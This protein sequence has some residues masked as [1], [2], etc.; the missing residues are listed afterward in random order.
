MTG[1]SLLAA[2]TP[3]N[4]PSRASKPDFREIASG[5]IDAARITITPSAENH[6]PSRE[7]DE[8]ESRIIHSL[9]NEGELEGEVNAMGTL[10]RRYAPEITKG[11][12]TRAHRA[13]FNLEE[14]KFIEVEFRMGKDINK[15][16]D[17]VLTDRGRQYQVPPDLA[18]KFTNKN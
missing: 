4:N 8:L 18:E 2:T 15:I 17:I 12:K 9:Q 5:A 10:I 6:E 16:S 1:I 3:E 7:L 13:L 14:A 11:K